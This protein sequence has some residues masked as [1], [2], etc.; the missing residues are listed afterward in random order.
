[1]PA[2]VASYWPFGGQAP[3]RAK[4][5]RLVQRDVI[6]TVRD[7]AESMSWA[8]YEGQPVTAV[9]SLMADVRR[10]DETVVTSKQAQAAIARSRRWTVT[11]GGIDPSSGSTFRGGY[12]PG[13]M[14]VVLGV[15]TPWPRG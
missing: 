1:M 8:T 5:Y 15:S 6:Q 7:P 3:S 14:Q 10:Y 13:L 11:P 4:V 2:T 12:A 9:A